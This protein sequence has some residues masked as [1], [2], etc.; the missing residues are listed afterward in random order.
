MTVLVTGAAGFAGAHVT[1]ALIAQGRRVI[2]V[3]RVPAASAHRLRDLVGRPGLEYAEGELHSLV[4]EV[5][6][7]VGG[8]GGVSGTGGAGTVSEVWHFA[9]NTD[10]PLSAQDTGIDIEESVLLTRQVLESMRRGGVG[11]IVFPS[12]SAVYGNAARTALR[13]DFGPL[14]PGSLYGAGKVSA[15]AVISAYCHLFGIRGWIF[16][17]GN[18]VGGQMARGIV[19]DFLRKLRQDA[20]ALPVL[21]DGRQRKSYVLVDDA[22]EAM[23]KISRSPG[24]SDTPCE[25]YNVASSGSLTVREVAAAVA[26]AL[27][28][29]EPRLEITTS[30]PSWPGD[31]PVVELDI[32]KAR[33]SGWSPR[34]TP[35]EAVVAAAR[36]L[37]TELEDERNP[38]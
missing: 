20:K 8:V 25:I 13:E 1:R 35:H 36:R 6:S 30:A 29:P 3:D 15:E 17:L 19:L 22:V 24:D 14:A 4:G 9:A 18:L 16:R 34:F 26:E 21:G 38:L 37:L 12:T 2:A 31:Q 5:I 11:K 23:I 33:A 27:G 10:I 7:G 32:S 28:E